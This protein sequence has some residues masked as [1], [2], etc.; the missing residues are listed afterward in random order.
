MSDCDSEYESLPEH[1][2]PAIHMVAGASAGILEH[3]IMFPFD[4]VKVGGHACRQ[5]AGKG[6]QRGS[7]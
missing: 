5:L 3:C 1:A 6:K 7:S 4:V 2:G